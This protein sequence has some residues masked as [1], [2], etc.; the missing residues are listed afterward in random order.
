M[1]FDEAG[2]FLEEQVSSLLAWLRSTDPHQRCR[3]IFASN[4]PRGAEGQ[5]LLRW[6]APWLDPAFPNPAQPGELRWYVRA[7]GETRWVD[8][9]GRYEVEGETYTARSRT[10]IPARLADNPY[11][12][13]TDYRAG[14]ENLPEP[15]RSQLLKG[16]FLAGREDDAWQVI[17]SAWVE[18]AQAR[19]TAGL[20]GPM[21]ALGVDV[22]QGGADFTVLAPRHGRWFGPL[23]TVPGR[24]TPDGVSVA[25]LVFGEVRNG[26]VVVVDAGGGW[27]SEAAGHLGR[28]LPDGRLVSFMGVAAST[29]SSVNGIAFVNLRAE[30][31]YRFRE[32]LDPQT[33]AGIALPPDPGLAAELAMPC[34]KLVS[35]AGKGAIQIEAKDEI[36]KRLGRSPDKADAVVMAWGYGGGR[37]E[38]ILDWSGPLQTRAKVGYARAKSWAR[39]RPDTVEPS[40]PDDLDFMGRQALQ[41]SYAR[42]GRNRT[43]GRL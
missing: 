11:L 26:A 24:Q 3:A 4:P 12:D 36:R 14:L 41:K 18:A 39:E 30:A 8:G 27:G 13:R 34:W 38:D 2:D 29:A 10:F 6:F 28:H 20:P 31:W 22:A 19:W 33:G 42:H 16:D 9:P 23:K 5:W 1:G 21:N 40:D 43:G 35:R 15:L 37:P 32:A 7:K 17:P 25:S